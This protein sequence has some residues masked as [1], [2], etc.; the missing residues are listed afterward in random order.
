M[1]IIYLLNVYIYID[2]CTYTY[3]DQKFHISLTVQG[4]TGTEWK[5]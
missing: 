2:V 4:Q 3:T 5:Y 1:C